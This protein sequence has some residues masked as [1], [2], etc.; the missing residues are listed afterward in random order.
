MNPYPDS[1]SILLQSILQCIL[2][3]ILLVSAALC[4]IHLEIEQ[5]F[6]ADNSKRDALTL[7]IPQVALSILYWKL[8]C[9][10]LACLLPAV[11]GTLLCHLPSA[12]HLPDVLFFLPPSPLNS[13]TSMLLPLDWSSRCSTSAPTKQ[14]SLELTVCT[15]ASIWAWVSDQNFIVTSAIGDIDHLSD[16]LAAAASMGER[17]LPRDKP[18]GR[19]ALGVW[20]APPPLSAPPLSAHS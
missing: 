5:S 8:V 4:N 6:S 20:P 10:P 3:W 12:I 7:I 16:L 13:F 9:L 11:I 15:D 14:V 19:H 18:D 1:G 2:Q 17:A